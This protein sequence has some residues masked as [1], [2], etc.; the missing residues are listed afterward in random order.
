M[1]VHSDGEFVASLKAATLEDIASVGSCHALAETMHAY[2]AADLRLI[3]SLDH[4][5]FFLFLEK[6]IT[7]SPMG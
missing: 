6:M 5:S 4:S 3:C 7:R 2:A 1:L